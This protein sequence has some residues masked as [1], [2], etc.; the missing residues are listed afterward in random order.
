[1]QQVPTQRP[2]GRSSRS[3][4]ANAKKQCNCKN[5]RC[6]KLYC[7]C[8]A[9][10]DFCAASCACLNCVNVQ[11]EREAVDAARD[12]VLF[13]NPDAFQKKVSAAE[14]HKKGCRCKRSR[15]LKKYCECFNAGARCNPEVCV[16]EG[17]RNKL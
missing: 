3:S 11:A 17:C 16:C 13:K 9:A 12:V 5:S 15:C 14:G 1:M 10:G 2:R 7:E 8:F 6:L 4:A